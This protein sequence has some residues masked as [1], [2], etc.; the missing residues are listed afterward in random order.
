MQNKPMNILSGSSGVGRSPNQAEEFTSQYLEPAANGSMASQVELKERRSVTRTRIDGCANILLAG[1]IAPRK[2]YPMDLTA[3][4]AR[5]DLGSLGVELDALFHFSF[6]KFRTMRVC[7]PI[8]RLGYVAGIQ[9]IGTVTSN[10]NQ[11]TLSPRDERQRL[12]RTLTIDLTIQASRIAPIDL[13]SNSE[14][15]E[16]GPTRSKLD[17]Q[18]RNSSKFLIGPFLP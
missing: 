6:D 7:R 8:W 4:G 11:G 10:Q 16:C 13:R 2:C 1:E 15:E 14:E 12:A 3:D 18:V 17:S 9:F 5:V